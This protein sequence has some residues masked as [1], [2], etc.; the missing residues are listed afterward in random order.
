MQIRWGESAEGGARDVFVLVVVMAA[1]VTRVCVFVCVISYSGFKDISLRARS[2]L[3]A[4]VYVPVCTHDC[5]HVHTC[6][7]MHKL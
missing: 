7:C 3:P 4:C 6:D 2:A 5:I 1:W